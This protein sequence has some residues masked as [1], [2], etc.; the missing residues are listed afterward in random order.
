[1]I[2][3]HYHEELSRTIHILENNTITDNIYKIDTHSTETLSLSL[4]NIFY[5]NTITYTPEEYLSHLKSTIKYQEKNKNYH[6]ITSTHKTFNNIT[7]INL[8]NNYTIISKN[9]NPT[10]H[11]VIKHPRLRDAIASFTSPIQEK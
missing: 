9:N 6:V 11:F 5:Q 3:S 2:I 1:M 4:E 8:L 10:I 7:I